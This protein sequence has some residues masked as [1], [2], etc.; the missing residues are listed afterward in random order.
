MWLSFDV[1]TDTSHA[2]TGLLHTPRRGDSRIGHDHAEARFLARGK[3]EPGRR[4]GMRLSARPVM[5]SRCW[6]SHSTGPWHKEVCLVRLDVST[7]TRQGGHQDDQRHHGRPGSGHR[8]GAREALLRRHARPYARVGDTGRHALP[9]RSVS[10]ISIFKRAPVATERTLAHFEVDDIVA[11][12]QDLQAK[13]VE[14]LGY[15]KVPCPPPATPLTW[16]PC[17]A[18]GSAIPTATP[19]GFD[20][21]ESA[22]ATR[23]PL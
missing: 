23:V 15:P 13:G 5:S 4:L 19:S 12:I 9:L 17:V 14:V 10:E 11:A 2:S 8:P 7:M 1:V 20:R 18:P 22:P 16:I 6:L 3:D 21:D